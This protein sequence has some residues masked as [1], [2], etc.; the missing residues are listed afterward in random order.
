MQFA[1][2]KLGYEQAVLTNAAMTPV[3]VIAV[4]G[5][6]RGSG[7]TSIAINLAQAL[8]M[9]GRRTLLL[10][11]D[12]GASNICE[13]LGLEPGFTLFDV[14]NGT[15]NLDEVLLDGPDG[16]QI[17]PAASNSRRLA[18]TGPWECAGLIRAFSDISSPVDTLVI[19]TASGI[20]DCTVSLCRAA[21]EVMVVLDNGQAS[22]DG[23]ASL[24]NALHRKDGLSHFRVL[25]SRVAS[26]REAS[27]LFATLLQC[28]SDNH[29]IALSCCGFIPADE[30]LGKAASGQRSVISTFPRSR[31]AMAL[32]NLAARVMKWP[33]SGQ[34]GGHLEFFVERLIQNDNLDLEVRS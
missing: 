32:K 2:I 30:S 4:T 8:S 31:S 14:F 16:V 3:Q 27:E 7:K 11:T 34:A 17:I 13:Q 18:E 33:R 12:P 20:G 19:D 29:E 22:L 9:A 21:G 23:A 10:D 25:P 15:I 6:D 5:V 1:D 24:I 28:F 26:A